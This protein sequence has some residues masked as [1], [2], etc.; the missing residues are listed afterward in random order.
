MK[1]KT[2][3]ALRPGSR[4]AVV[5]P[6]STPPKAEV[7]K[8]A[9]ALRAMGYVPVLYPHVLDNGPLYFA[10]PAAGR[11]DDLHRAFADPTI[12][13]VHCARGGYG[14]VELLPLLNKKMIAENPKPMIGYSDITS[15]HIFLQNE[16]GLVT[17]HGPMAA[18][19]F[20][21]PNGVDH[22]SW[23]HALEGDTGGAEWSVGAADGMRVLRPGRA[24]GVLRGG[25][26]SIVV[27]ALGTPFA[28]Q[29]D[30]DILFLE[31]VNTWPYQVDRM[32]VQLKYALK[33]Q[34][35]RGIVFGVF[36]GSVDPKGSAEARA[37]TVE[38]SILHVLQDFD[39]PIAFGLRS[40]HV[41]GPNITLPLG[42]SVDLDLTNSAAPKLTFI[43][44]SVA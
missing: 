24:S 23:K 33:F 14:S 37:I 36:K 7:D 43:Q 13:A 17:F 40:G 30:G 42:V 8:G 21:Y 35:V 41:S 2:L 5:S 3:R 31:D 16:C 26:L 12:D 15:L 38:D 9:D 32:L 44:P 27:A 19:D 18:S 29:F 34:K 1:Q 25:C 28:P 10:G 39:G 22:A 20:S 11:L 4:I 6:A